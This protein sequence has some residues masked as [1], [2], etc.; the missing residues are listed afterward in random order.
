MQ[1][2]MNTQPITLQLPDELIEQAAKIAG[3]PEDMHD[4]FVGAIEHEIERCKQSQP[5]PD[6]ITA[7]SKFREELVREGIEINPDE[8]WG[9]VRQQAAKLAENPEALKS[10]FWENV[11]GLRAQ[12]QAEG[13]EIDPEDI[14]GDVRHRSPGRDINL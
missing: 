10:S 5:K 11:Q 4:F 1:T 6:F 12:M 9:D 7:L 13:I 2:S 14:W 8:I 3:N